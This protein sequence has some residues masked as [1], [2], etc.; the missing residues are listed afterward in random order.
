MSRPRNAD[1][2]RTRAAILDAAL[3]LFAEK[4]FFGTTLRDI[5]TAVGVR[6]SA[7][8]N[9][10]PGKDAL[11]EELIV[12]SQEEKHEQMQAIAA[13]ESLDLRDALEQLA[14]A[15]LRNYELP[16]QQRLFRV[17]LSDGIRLAR[18][19]RMN[20]LERMGSAGRGPIHDLLRRAVRQRAV[21]NSDLSMMVLAFVSPLM[22][23][24][25]ARAVEAQVPMFQHLDAFVRLHVDQFLC[26]AAASAAAAEPHAPRRR[27]VRTTRTVAR[28]GRRR[29][30]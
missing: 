25:Q 15:L 30:S 23:W 4:G 21:R 22:L 17:L 29:A 10:F 6:E 8:Y 2:Q 20:L 26:G 24:R 11:F 14:I 18:N 16:R 9:Y 12:T 28:L 1:G 13:D 19:G 3:D 5:A 7:L 27:P